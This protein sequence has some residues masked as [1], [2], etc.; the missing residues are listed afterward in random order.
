MNRRSFLLSAGLFFSFAAK[1]KSET[2]LMNIAYFNNYPP[3]SWDNG[4]GM[5]GLLIDIL[6]EVFDKRMGIKT[7]HT[8][9]PWT[10]A[11][12]LVEQGQADAF[13]T[14]PTA[15]R[16]RYTEV[17]EELTV[18]A[19]FTFF[20][21]KGAEI[22]T[23]LSQVQSLNDLKK[24]RVGHYIGSGWAKKNLKGKVLHLEEAPS[25]DGVLF[26][27]TAGRVDTVIDTSQ[28]V[29]YRVKQ[30]GLEGSIEELPQVLDHSPFS[31]CIGK[32]SPFVSQL[33]LFNEHMRELRE[34][35]LYTNIV[36]RYT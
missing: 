12:M 32:K 25:L 10:R 24:F 27:L 36:N 15:E 31:L 28:V 16:R 23:E 29:R 4:D 1:G 30:L 13:C 7:S 18:L 26:M 14:V 11:Q 9:Y 35:D 34:S 20:V 6:T 33:S 17:S 2:D 22:N 3:F 19:T 8:G 21:R 5:Q